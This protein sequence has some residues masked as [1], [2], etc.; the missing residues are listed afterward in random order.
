MMGAMI[1]VTNHLKSSNSIEATTEVSQSGER[2]KE[3]L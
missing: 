3:N 2:E 1:T